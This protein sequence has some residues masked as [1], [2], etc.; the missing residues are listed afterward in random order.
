[1]IDPASVAFDIDGV[2]A[3]TM[4]LFLEIA[5]DAFRI[6]GIRYED[7]SCY[8]LAECI[9]IEPEVIDA[10]VDRILV[11]DYHT[12]LRPIDGAVNVLARIGRDYGPLLLVT[13]RPYPGPIT[14]WLSNLLPLDPGAIE[15]VA[16]GSFEYKADVLKQRKVACFVEDRL[17]T[18]YQ[19]KEAGIM[20]VVFKQ[21]WNRQP[22]PFL[23]VESWRQLESLIKF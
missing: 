23:E 11:G 22:H 2:I 21:P 18:C 8:N 13:A 16:T 5:R 7:I 10:V 6:S 19:L 20:P 14:Q 4:S 15:L 17:E 9:P 1:M 12:P 3:D